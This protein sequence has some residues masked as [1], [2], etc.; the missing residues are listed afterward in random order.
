M[1]VLLIAV[2]GVG[3]VL[4]YRLASDKLRN[5]SAPG[6]SPAA[7]PPASSPTPKQ[8]VPAPRPTRTVRP[9]TTKPTIKP[10]TRPP[11]ATP[12]GSAAELARRFVAQLNANNST[13]A[14]ALACKSSK[15][16]IPWLMG[17]YLQPPTRLT[18]GTVVGD[19]TTFV[20]PL[21]GTTKRS[22][23]TGVIVIKK[24]TPEP[25]CIGAFSAGPG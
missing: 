18:P 21:S 1:L 3:G 6:P 13:K 17:Q 7:A 2:L 24:I 22:T 4:A 9:P 20:V 19:Q 12:A 14:A 23:V 16:L 25:L 10:T 15:Q 11:A 8:S 5:S